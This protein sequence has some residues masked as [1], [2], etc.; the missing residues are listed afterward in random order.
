MIK[1]YLTVECIRLGKMMLLRGINYNI[2]IP[3]L[4]YFGVYQDEAQKLELYKD[5][6]TFLG[7]NQTPKNWQNGSACFFVNIGNF[8]I[9]IALHFWMSAVCSEII[10]FKIPNIDRRNV[11]HKMGDFF[12]HFVTFTS[13]PAVVVVFV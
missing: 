8:L 4:S 3:H 10:V 6:D 12:S 5:I 2:L 1:A 7:R 13:T 11:H 9:Y